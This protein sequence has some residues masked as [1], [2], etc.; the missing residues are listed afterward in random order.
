MACIVTAI[1]LTACSSSGEFPGDPPDFPPSGNDATLSSLSISGATLN[2]TFSSSV[3]NYSV[4]VPQGS[5]SVSLN[6]S[7]SDLFA[8]FVIIGN[9]DSISVGDNTLDIRVTAEDGTTQ[10]TYSILI[11][12]LN[13]AQEAYAKA[14]NTDM[15]D[16]FGGTVALSADGNTMAVAA[17]NESSASTGVDG[18]QTNNDSINA[19]AVYVFVRDNAGAWVQQAYL[20]ASNTDADPEFAEDFFG[21]SLALSADGSTLAVGA[22]REDSSATG[23]DGDQANN[24]TRFAGAVYVFTR[25]AVDTWAQ[26]AYVKASNTGAIDFFGRSVSLSADGNTLAAG[27]F[28]EDGSATGV[29]GNDADNNAIDAGAIFVFA[30]DVGGSWTQQDYVKAS[31]TGSGDRFGFSVSLSADGDTMAVGAQNEDSAAT[32]VNGDGLDD[33]AIDS[34]AA[35]V[36]TRDTGGVWTEQAYLKASNTE[37]GDNFGFSIK[38]SSDGNTLAVSAWREDG[39]DSGNEADNS[40]ADSGAA[41]IFTRDTGGVWSQQAYVKA[42]SPDASDHFG[43]NLSLSGDASKLA[44]G[45]HHED[46]AATEVDGDQ[47]DNT[48]DSAG[49]VYVFSSENG[50]NWAQQAYVKASNA[51][52]GDNFGVSVALPEDGNLLAVGAHREDSA[53]TGVDGDQMDDSVESAGAVYV[54]Q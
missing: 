16:I 42:A 9:T 22:T 7:T 45:A 31:N 36:F 14:S 46:G 33:S 43:W 34:G 23:V 24:D 5:S 8:S 21:L 2:P 38:V 3:T 39:G 37:A 41:F 49:T 53:A 11:T 25:D 10:Q 47:L 40:A 18:D 12:R 6:I 15:D 17:Q 48:A 28:L 52:A 44:V 20:K 27:A 50:G 30:R 13:F 19:G 1:L 26:Q 29:N 4:T 51:S 54:F 35:Y 32:G